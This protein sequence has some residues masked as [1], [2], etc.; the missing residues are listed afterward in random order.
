MAR[1]IRRSTCSFWKT[2]PV[3][4][5]FFAALLWGLVSQGMGFLNKYSS[6]DDIFQLFGTGS[7]ITSGRWMLFVLEQAEN[8]LW[9]G[10][11]SLPLFNGMLSLLCIGASAGLIA[12]LLRIRSPLLGAL[13]GA[14]MS[15]FPTVTAIFSFMFTAHFYFLA[16]LMITGSACLIC[17]DTS[18]KLK[19]PGIMLGAC[20]VGIYQAFLPVLP[21]LLLL[22]DLREL[23]A[24]EAKASIVLRKLLLQAAAIVL[25]LLLYLAGS[26]FFLWKY[27]M[28]LD[29]YMGINQATSTSPL[30]YL[31]RAGDAYQ[32]F[33]LPSRN[34]GWDMY[35][36][37]GHL[38]YLLMLWADGIMG[39]L[40]AVR[41]GQSN[42][43]RAALM[44]LLLLL[45]PLGCNFIFVMSTTIH[46]LMVYGQVLQA[47]L[48]IL[49]ATQVSRFH[50]EW[51]RLAMGAATLLLAGMCVIYARYDN[52]FY[53]KADFQKQEAIS[54]NTALV[55]RIKS[56]E[57]YRDEL[58]VAWVN[59]FDAE[60][61]SLYQMQELERIH[62]SGYENTLQE[63]M[64]NYA[65]EKFLAYWC[66]FSP[67]TVDPETISHL[68]AVEQMPPYPEDGSVRVLDGVVVVKF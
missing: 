57:G 25:V 6:N 44:V 52:Q 50:P 29:S 22:S 14:V 15:A 26:R 53:L 39:I 66:G 17:T 28:E 4:A 19:I 7:T 49:L 31:H 30:V 5:A 12:S 67:D 54:W 35:P 60:D 23:S 13:L 38:L 37:R 43:D 62:L 47:A 63:Y 21:A 18:W 59:R 16:L 3:Q 20:A 24:E 61:R 42:R 2:R 45:F 9:G 56:T 32:E 55:A 41:I 33:F 27:G 68:P 10:H 51:K 36:G 46:G 48:L 11:C 65:W 64:N 58:P 8:L 1:E 40:L 34:T